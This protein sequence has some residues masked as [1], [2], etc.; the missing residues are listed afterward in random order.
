MNHPRP[1][2]WV[3]YL[4][5]ESPAQTRRV[6]KQHL[7]GCP[8]CRSQLAEWRASLKRLDSWKL[9]RAQ[10]PARLLLAPATLKWAFAALALLLAGFAAGRFGTA[11]PDTATLQASITPA[12]RNTLLQD[13][14]VVAREQASQVAAATLRAGGTEAE[15]SAAAYAKALEAQRAEDRRAIDAVLARLETQHM[16]DLAALKQQL[17]TLALNTDA[18]LRHTAQGLVLLANYRETPTA[19]ESPRKSTQ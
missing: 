3:P 15:R 7:S 17:D 16:A 6:L 18:S 8:E 10:A 11:R 2:E 1:E 12:L 14:A 9:P 19:T 5:G 13:L 4:S